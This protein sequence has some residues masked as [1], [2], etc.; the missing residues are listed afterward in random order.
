[1]K[2]LYV[3]TNVFLRYFLND[4]T[5][6]SNLARKYFLQAQKNNCKLFTIPQILFEFAYVLKSVYKRNK[7][8]VVTHLKIILSMNFLVINNKEELKQATVIYQNK[9]ID[10][11]DAYLFVCAQT[12][13]AEVFSFDKDFKKLN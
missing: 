3:D 7:K 6:Q 10:L 12:N 13:Q 4:N 11:V 9:N 1:M 5:R 2:K 8:D